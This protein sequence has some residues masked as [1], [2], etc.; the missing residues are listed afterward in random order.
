MSGRIVLRNTFLHVCE[1][2]TEA[3][4][5]ARCR[6]W[7]AARKN[8]LLSSGSDAADC[9]RYCQKL[10]DVMYASDSAAKALCSQTGDEALL[11]VTSDDETCMSRST[12]MAGSDWS[13]EDA[14]TPRGNGS[15]CRGAADLAKSI[16]LMLCGLPCRMNVEQLVATVHGLGYA[17]TFYFVKLPQGARQS[18]LG[19]AFVSFKR[20]DVAYAFARDFAKHRFEGH[21]TQKK[22]SVRLASMQSLDDIRQAIMGHRPLPKKMARVIWL[23]HSTRAEAVM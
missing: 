16:T 7:P 19:Y 17:G 9:N 15:G 22:P 10:N 6:S 23:P 1:G 20:S 11:K 12:T 3:R 4:G 21:N 13:D 2:P 14:M 18:N 5:L 8:P